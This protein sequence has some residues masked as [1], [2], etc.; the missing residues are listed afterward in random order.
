VPLFFDVSRVTLT[1][2]QEYLLGE[3]VA[4]KEAL[5]GT[6]GPEQL[7]ERLSPGAR[8]GLSKIDFVHFLDVCRRAGLADP[9]PDG[10]VE[11]GPCDK[12]RFRIT[13][14]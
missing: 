2:G 12:A 10:T 1:P 8:E 14:N 4:H 7:Y 9:G 3:L 6:L 13:F 5:D 11:L